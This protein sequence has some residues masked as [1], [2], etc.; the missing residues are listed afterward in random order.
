MQIADETTS[1]TSSVR[2][3]GPSAVLEMSWCIHAAYSEYLRTAHPILDDLYGRHP[4]IR[5]R[6]FSFWP[7]TMQCFTEFEIL[8]HHADV[9]EVSD[10]AV[11]RSQIDSTIASMSIDLDLASETPE[12]RTVILSRVAQ[13]KASA[14]LRRKYFELLADIWSIVGPWWDSV[15]ASSVERAAVEFRSALARGTEW[16]QL[17]SPECETFVAHLPEIITRSVPGHQLLLIP[18]ALFGKGLYLELP[19][20][21]LVGFGLSGKA[22]EA[23]SRT[24]H[25]AA[26]L[27]VLADPT[28]LAIFEYL[29]SGPA[30][31]G[32]IAQA[33]ELAQPTVS[34]HIKRLRE[35]G[36][37]SADRKGNRLQMSVDRM[38]SERLASEI[39]L[40][41][42]S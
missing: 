9:L 5:E 6:I 32:D 27:R 42:T 4:E 37:V 10:F 40:L 30:S 41:L 34:I 26:P 15:G 21:T 17:V 38:V 12:D 16:Q 14:K 11:A 7:D 3:S 22:G 24:E 36:L 2:V 18:C 31:V 29:K 33:F 8:A 1:V 39:A 25:V 13:L 19:G 20:C 28:R 23:R 35:A